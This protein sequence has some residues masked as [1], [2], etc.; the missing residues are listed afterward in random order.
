MARATAVTIGIASVLMVVLSV[1]SI[2]D[3]DLTPPLAPEGRYLDINL[4]GDA[5]LDLSPAAA[6]AAARAT[7][8]IARIGGLVGR[9]VRG[10]GDG[11]DSDHRRASVAQPD[12]GC[13]VT[14]DRVPD[15]LSPPC[16]RPRT[17]DLGPR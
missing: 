15:L 8:F 16:T 9:I 3:L 10:Q 12:G 13:I 5:S 7:P 11:G 14:W 6:A 1:L 4:N 17:T 2:K